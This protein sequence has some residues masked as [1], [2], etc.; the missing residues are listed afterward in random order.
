MLYHFGDQTEVAKVVETQSN[1]E[2][3]LELIETHQQEVILPTLC[4]IFFVQ[5]S[6]GSV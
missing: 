2:R 3:Q 1:L 5:E 6:V 4:Y